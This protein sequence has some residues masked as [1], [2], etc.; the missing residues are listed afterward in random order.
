MLGY[1]KLSRKENVHSVLFF[2]ILVT[3]SVRAHEIPNSEEWFDVPLKGD[4]LIKRGGYNFKD[5]KV[6]VYPDEPAGSHLEYATAD[7]F[8]SVKATF[9]DPTFSG[10]FGLVLNSRLKLELNLKKWSIT[11]FDWKDGSWKPRFSSK[12]QGPFRYRYYAKKLF[13]RAEQSKIVVYLDGFPIIQ[14][15]RDEVDSIKS[16]A[17]ISG[18]ARYFAWSQIKF[19]TSRPDSDRLNG[20]N[21]LRQP[22]C[23]NALQRA[24]GQSNEHGIYGATEQ[25]SI[26]SS[27]WLGDAC[28][29]DSLTLLVEDFF[30]DVVYER[31]DSIEPL[32]RP[33]TIFNFR[34]EGPG[35]FKLVALGR[36][37]DG[38]TVFIRDLLAW[39]SLPPANDGP[40]TV[41]IG[42]HIDAIE[43]GKHADVAEKL[44]IRWIRHHDGIQTGYWSRVQPDRGAAPSWRYD[45]VVTRLGRLGFSSLG[46]ILSTPTWAASDGAVRR[47][48]GTWVPDLDMFRMYVSSLV[49]RYKDE[50]RVWEIW[51]EPYSRNYWGGSAEEYAEL[52][53]AAYEAIKE[54][55][56]SIT[57]VGGGGVL[58]HKT[59]WLERMLDAG[60]A[61]Y[62]DVFSIHYLNA[63]TADGD[64]QRIRA[65]LKRHGFEGPIWNTE[66]S[67]PSDSMLR[68]EHSTA[69]N[70]S[71]QL[72]T[73][74][75]GASRELVR[76]YLA[77]L[78]NGIEGIF[79]HHQIEPTRF[80]KLPLRLRK[81]QK[82][83]SNGFW[84][85]DGYLK[86]LAVAHS[87]FVSEIADASYSRKLAL[88]RFLTAYVFKTRSGLLVIFLDESI[89]SQAQVSITCGSFSRERIAQFYL[90]N[91]MGQ[92]ILVGDSLCGES[93]PLAGFP[94][95]L[96][97]RDVGESVNLEKVLVG[98]IAN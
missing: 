66:M 23:E 4:W 27:E 21:L 47:K 91:V 57:V 75:R 37:G 43:V 42:G 73:S 59:S 97:L 28:R 94:L 76:N 60:A 45:D 16:V 25:V 1:I 68:S 95:Y 98:S 89:N 15:P 8:Y 88:G 19:S 58:P 24:I 84:D 87:V 9:E 52:L 13:F 36:D 96:Y 65:L 20:N 50:I 48:A 93:V 33:K 17:F 38:R 85:S 40:P 44:G 2:L 35:A 18:G 14:F 62:L 31:T 74:Y 92:K 22:A 11:V 61:R 6:Y 54:V 86:P 64:I 56:S 46:V 32:N 53:R 3:A 30:G 79:Y 5:A 26:R 12:V 78:S 81:K 29:F 51:N 63:D 80:G 82:A 41:R 7:S 71:V 34:L 69:L 70:D 55:D 39:V 49:S 83:A 77:N 67:V 10:W 90:K 72:G